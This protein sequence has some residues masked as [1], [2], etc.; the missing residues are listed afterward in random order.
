MMVA[1]LRNQW[2]LIWGEASRAI[3][4]SDIDAQCLLQP[5]LA[6][7]VV[8]RTFSNNFMTTEIC[9]L[10]CVAKC[11]P[12]GVT[13]KDVCRRSWLLK[14]ILLCHCDPIVPPVPLREAARRA[15]SEQNNNSGMTRQEVNVLYNSKALRSCKCSIWT[16]DTQESRIKNTIFWC[17]CYFSYHFLDIF[18][19]LWYPEVAAFEKDHLTLYLNKVLAS[20]RLK[21]SR[22]E[23]DSTLRLVAAAA[24]YISVLYRGRVSRTW[25]QQDSSSPTSSLVWRQHSWLKISFPSTWSFGW[26][27]R[28]ASCFTVFSGFRFLCK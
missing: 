27:T 25:F 10:K 13:A 9:F 4:L 3:C 2:V 11:Q 17:K 6:W 1:V 16:Q 22:K 23:E 14:R 15:A 24:A 7:G 12:R 26:R 18:K 8:L 28:C 5:G 20:D 21:I 19:R